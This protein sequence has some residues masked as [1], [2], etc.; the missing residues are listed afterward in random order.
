MTRHPTTT[1]ARADTRTKFLTQQEMRTLLQA[2][3]SKRDHAIFLI[4]A[5]VKITFTSVGNEAGSPGVYPLEE[6][7]ERV[8][9]ECRPSRYKKENVHFCGVTSIR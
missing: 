7:L 1:P 4:A 6:P 8:D 5:L 3:D 2:I 9:A